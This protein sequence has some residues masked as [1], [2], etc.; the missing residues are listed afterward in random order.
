MR[1]GLR[2]EDDKIQQV[3]KFKYL[4][5]VTIEE[6]KCDSVIRRCIGLAKDSSKLSTVL[7][8]RKKVLN[9]YVISVLMIVD[10]GQ[11]LHIKKR[12]ETAVVVLQKDTENT[13][14]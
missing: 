7:M 12:P 13:F 11:S 8:N 1:C 14:F 9:C 2:N 10:A 3:R 5:N 4:R 6:G